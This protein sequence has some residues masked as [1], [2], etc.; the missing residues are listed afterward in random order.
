MRLAGEL[1]VV[2]VTQDEASL[3]AGARARFFDSTWT[4]RPGGWTAAIGAAV[5]RAVA[6]HHGGEAALVPAGK[7]GTTLR[8]TFTRS[9][10]SGPH[11]KPRASSPKPQAPSLHYDGI[12]RPCLM[13]PTRRC[14]LARLP[15]L[16]RRRHFRR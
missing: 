6:Q 1:R 4:D 14:A 8:L 12:R 13:H 11:R 15:A 3:P 7:R 10:E 5:A 16:V 2:E 9:A